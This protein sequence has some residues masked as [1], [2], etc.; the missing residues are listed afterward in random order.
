MPP[1]KSKKATSGATKV[2]KSG[3][4]KPS[5]KASAPSKKAAAA[6][7][8]TV[9]AQRPYRDVAEGAGGT[10]RMA[11]TAAIQAIG[12]VA[13]ETCLGLDVPTAPGRIFIAHFS[14]EPQEDNGAARAQ[15]LANYVV[16]PGCYRAVVMT[17]K[18]FLNDEQ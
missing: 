3:S 6:K 10:Y 2:T 18:E 4:K 13:C 12:T 9:A 8:G 5:K 7:S 1:K 17:T 11:P 15:V 14:F 16:G